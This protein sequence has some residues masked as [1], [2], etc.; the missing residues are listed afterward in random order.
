MRASFYEDEDAYYDG[1]DEPR[2][3][4]EALLDEPG[5]CCICD[6][7]DQRHAC[8]SCGKPV[9]MH[10]IDYLADTRCGGWI[11]D[12]WHPVAPDENE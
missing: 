7:P 10:P 1:N 9:C 2:E 6:K 8:F 5:P 4:P 11:L 12:S 3:L